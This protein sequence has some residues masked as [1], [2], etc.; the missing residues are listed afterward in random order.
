MLISKAKAII[1]S[2]T[3]ADAI[4]IRIA[5][6]I[7]VAT[8]TETSG[9]NVSKILQGVPFRWLDLVCHALNYLDYRH[10]LMLL[11]KTCMY[12]RKANKS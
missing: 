3:K 9:T 7:C 6:W 10:K 1:F 11:D 8:S 2:A 4:P 5:R 12:S